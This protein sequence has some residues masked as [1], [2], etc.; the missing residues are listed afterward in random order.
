LQTHLASIKRQFGY[1][2]VDFFTPNETCTLDET[3]AFWIQNA[4]IIIILYDASLIADDDLME[5]V[6]KTLTQK[7]PKAGLFSYLINFIANPDALETMK[8]YNGLKDGFGI[9]AGDDEKMAKIAEV[10][11][12]R[13]N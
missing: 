8:L 1:K 3:R 7:K 6:S 4:E 11:K 12:R 10:I 2:F 13:H 5:W 9:I